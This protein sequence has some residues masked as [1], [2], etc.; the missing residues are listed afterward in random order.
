ML[1]AQ[2]EIVLPI[3]IFGLFLMGVPQPV[4]QPQTISDE[5]KVAVYSLPDPLRLAS[6]MRVA[7]AAAW[8]NKRRPELLKLFE[9]EEYGKTLVGRPKSLKFVVREEK[10]DARGGKATRLRIGILF[11]GAET[12]R[13]MELLVYLPNHVKGPA[14]LFLGLNFDGNYATTDEPDIPLPTHWV[15]GLFNNKPINNKPPASARGMHKELWQIDNVLDHGYGLAMAC[16]GEVEP[17]AVGHWQ[18]GPRGLGPQPGTGDWGTIGAWAWSL[19]R[20][21]DYLQTNKRVDA[22]R[23]ALTGFSRLGKA[24]LWAGAQDERFSLVVS[25]ESGAGGA[26]LHKRI[27]GE[28]AGDLSRRFPHWFCPNFAKYAE[29]EAAMPMDQHELIALIAPRP[30]L[31][32]SADNDL[33]SDPKG[34]FL[35]GLGADPVY[36]LLTGEGIARTEWPKAQDL[37]DSRIGYYLRPGPHDVTAEDWRVMIQFAE[38]WMKQNH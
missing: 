21:M 27:F 23:V 10:R 1:F 7:D 31:I 2:G 19:S 18:D 4:Q 37:I 38:K 32:I 29:N 15:N 17:D 12:G 13:Q 25:N 36:K 8:R 34:E 3:S 11:E 30:V 14:P 26:A 16:Y 24:A 28:T 20:A 33:W 9:A 22:K 6:G 35:G 5:S